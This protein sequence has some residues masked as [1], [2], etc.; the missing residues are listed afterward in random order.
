MD[1]AMTELVA[2][3]EREDG[4]ERLQAISFNE[5]IKELWRGRWILLLCLVLALA[6]GLATTINSIPQYSAQLKIAPA[7]SNFSQTGN[8]TT[9]SLVS[10]I[11]GGSQQ[12]DDYA[13]FLDLLHSVRLADDLEKRYH[14]MQDVFPY[15]VNKKEFLPDGG[16]LPWLVR[17]FRSQLGMPAWRPPTT[18]D[19]AAYLTSAVDIDR[20]A[21][22]SAT[23][24]YHNRDATVAGTFLRHVFDD[25]DRLLREE[26]LRSRTAMRDYV[27]KRLNDATTIDQ[28]AVLI[29]L[30]GTEETQM[31]LLASGDPVG[32]RVIDDANVSNLPST[33][34]GRIMLIAILAGLVIGMLVVIVRSAMKRA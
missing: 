20:H 24:T 3:Y 2:T 4:R 6:L 29:Q 9:Q 16:I 15:D 30:W 18:V 1:Q 32:A 19:L 34:A 21:D 23:L 7:E 31:L 17:T 33:G 12:Y 13:H 27:S 11:T 28:R 22:S 26:K 10:V 25:T 14:V 5:L 8:T